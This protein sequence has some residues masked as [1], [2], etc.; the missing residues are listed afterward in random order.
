MLDMTPDQKR[1][2]EQARALLGTPF[3]HQGRVSGPHGGVDCVGAIILIAR[4]LG[5]VSPDFDLSGY[6]SDPDGTLLPLLAEHLQ[7]IE[8]KD[9]GPG[10]VA[11]FVVDKEPQHVGVLVPYVHGGLA[12]VHACIRS[13]RVVEHRMVFGPRLR[14]VQAFRFPGRAA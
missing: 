5:H 6:T 14:L 1:I 11:A 12:L 2:V 10:D 3:A 9:A 13:G 4:A 7:P 8:P